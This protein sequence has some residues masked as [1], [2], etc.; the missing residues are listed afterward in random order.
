MAAAALVDALMDFGAR[1][2]LV[3]PRVVAEPPP[4]PPIIHPPEPE[5]DVEALV[6]EAVAQAEAEVSARFAA[7]MELQLKEAEDRHQAE[8]ERIRSETGVELGAR[9]TAALADL[10]RRTIDVTT[11]VVARILGQVATDAIAERAVTALASTV[12]DV[13]DDAETVRI[14]VRGPQS[15]FLPFAAA[16]GEQSRH[17]EFVEAD[18]VDL[19]VSIEEALFE[20]R[21]AEWSKTLAETI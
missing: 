20:T 18:T 6:A 9:I 5:I 19:T 7:E 13:I 15:L 12:R 3:T 8:I 21:L 14:R 4:P 2:R 11:S 17:L 1:P 16:M 10:E